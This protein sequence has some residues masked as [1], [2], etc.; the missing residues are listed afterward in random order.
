MIGKSAPN[1][2]SE[3]KKFQAL[4]IF[5][6]KSRKRLYRLVPPNLFAW[7][8]ANKIG[9]KWLKQG[10]YTNLI[11]LTI[12]KFKEKFGENLLSLGIFGSV[13][14]NMARSSS[15]LDLLIIFN[16][17]PNSMG[18]R[19]RLLLE[20]ENNKE[21]QN[22]L[23]FLNSKTIF[24]RFNYHPIR[25]SELQVT[26]LL[27]DASFDMKIIYDNETLENFLFEVKKKIR[28]LNIERKYLGKNNYYLDL[29]IPFGTVLEF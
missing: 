6:R 11:L 19:L 3:L 17:L 23:A 4:F 21:I 5:T 28:E 24:P 15:D 13:S 25:E 26:P 27:I 14:R 20:I 1:Y 7:A 18:E 10:A 2:L 29:K 22:E 16:T 12:M 9:L 8:I